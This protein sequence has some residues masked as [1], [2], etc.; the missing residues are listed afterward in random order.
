VRGRTVGAAY[1]RGKWLFVPLEKG[2]VLVFGECGGRIHLHESAASIPRKYHLALIFEDGSGLSAV[3][4]MW[5]A[6][7]LYEQGKE[8][9]RKYIHGMRTTPIDEEF[10]PG[11]LAGLMKE[12]I[13]N[14]NRTVK[15][16]LTQDQLIPGLGN[17]IAQD[18]MFQARLH[19][20]QPL[21][22]LDPKQVQALHKA[23]V[24]TL[25]EAIRLGGRNDEYDLYGNAGKYIRLMDM[26]TVGKPCPRCGTRIVKMAYLGGT[27]YV[28]PA[29]QQLK[30]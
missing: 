10:D 2:Y 22:S 27:C 5:G 21:E 25:R 19:P 17:A 20:K 3:T 29:C 13:R 6:M 24:E 23:I 18:I 26:N 15:A 14:G 8:K 9:Q 11:Y 4:R 1:T 12:A 30:Q 7:E 28:C 16:I